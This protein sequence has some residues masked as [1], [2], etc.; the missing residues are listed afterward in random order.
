MMIDV[1]VNLSRWPF[2]RLPC[3]THDRLTLKLHQHDVVQA[4]VSSFDAVL[5]R[6]LGGVNLRLAEACKE[7]GNVQLVPFGTVNPMSPDWHEDLRR[8]HED[9]RMPGIRLLPNYHDYSLENTAVA[10][11]FQLAENRGLVVQ[12]AFRMED[13]RT[14]HPRLQVPDV[15]PAA[16]PTLA[17]RHPRLKLVLLNWQPAVTGTPLKQLAAA[18]NVFFD[19]AMCEGVGGVGSLLETV[20]VERVLFGSY[21]PFFNLESSL[22]KIRESPLTPEQIKAITHENATRLSTDGASR[23]TNSNS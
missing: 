19:I 3:D 13:P 16:L 18:P 2:R 1:N 21:F 23:I 20:S 12:V 22:L 11:L 6:D 17:G 8:C 9:Y 5:H 7:S 14:Q 15:D 4:W 10:E